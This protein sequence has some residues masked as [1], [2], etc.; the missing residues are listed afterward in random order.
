M[1]SQ[2]LLAFIILAIVITGIFGN[3]ISIII[4]SRAHMRA[5]P[6]NILLCALSTVDLALLL[7]SIPVFVIPG[8]EPWL[9]VS[10]LYEYYAYMLKFVYPINLI[11]QTCSIYI[12]VL[13]TMERWSAV[14][15]PLQVRIW[16]TAKK[17][18]NAVFIIFL[19][20]ILYNIPRFF[21]YTIETADNGN[22]IYARNLRDP[23]LYPYYMIGYFTTCYLITHFIVPF[24]IIIVMNLNVCWTMFAMSRIRSDLTHQQQRENSTTIMLLVV[25]I[26]FASCNLLPFVL[27]LIECIIPDFFTNSN[28]TKL[29][30]QLNDISNLLVILNSAITFI[31]YFI[32]SEKYR[33]TLQM[34][35]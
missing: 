2:N 10:V 33:K 31:I 29:A 35:R 1:D 19:C 8:L 34:L 14:C 27:N 12:M 24:G 18:R 26:L 4:F 25:T 32:F 17:S 23:H 9:N 5:L 13:I 3:F 20:A 16:C 21:E 6:V 28:T 11:M 30:Y 7:L 15:K 22:V